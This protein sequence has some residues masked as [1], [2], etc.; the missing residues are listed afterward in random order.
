ML[1][2]M[3]VCSEQNEL[4]TLVTTTAQKRINSELTEMNSDDLCHMSHAAMEKRSDDTCASFLGAEISLM[5]QSHNN[6]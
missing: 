5:S 6:L 1:Q 3:F 4:K 2:F